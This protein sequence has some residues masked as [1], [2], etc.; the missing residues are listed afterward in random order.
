MKKK[1]NYALVATK[2]AWKGEKNDVLDFF[3]VIPWKLSSQNSQNA[4]VYV[5]SADRHA[6][7]FFLCVCVNSK[8][9]KIKCVVLFIYGHIYVISEE[10][11]FGRWSPS[12]VRKLC[13]H[14]QLL[15]E[16]T[17]TF[18]YFMTENSLS[19]M[20]VWRHRWAMLLKMKRSD[21]V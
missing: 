9:T 6:L 8:Y 3:F 18:Y 19:F 4:L 7:L 10:M 13:L 5:V 16:W 2:S 21:I 12:P 14:I 20:M 17:C 1:R 15:T 11:L